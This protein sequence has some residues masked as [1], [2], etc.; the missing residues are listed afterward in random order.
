L[1]VGAKAAD[2]G[3]VGRAVLGAEGAYRPFE[4]SGVC[5]VIHLPMRR[6]PRR[7]RWGKG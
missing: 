4:G 1:L 7:Q 2:N 5:D 3:T 6:N